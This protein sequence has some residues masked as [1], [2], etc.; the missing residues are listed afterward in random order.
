M[1]LP[2]NINN[3]F[4]NS[5]DQKNL[6]THPVILV[7]NNESKIFPSKNLKGKICLS[8]FVSISISIHGDITLCGC[9]DWMPTTVGNIYNAPLSELL[10]S[11]LAQRI[12]KSIVDGTYIFCNEKTC[13]IIRNNLLNDTHTVPDNVV[14]Q[15]QDSNRYRMPKEIFIAGDLTCNLSC[16]S[17]RTKII[18]LTEQQKQQQQKLVDTFRNN[19]FSEPSDQEIVLTVS[20]SGE[21]FA[22]S[23]LLSFISGISLTNYPNLGLNIQTNGL[24]CEKNWSRL[25]PLQQSVKKI[26]VTIDAAKSDTYEKLRRGGTWDQIMSSMA[27]LQAKKKQNSMALHTR[28]VIQ[29]DNFDQMED[30]Y[31]MSKNFDADVV[32]YARISDWKTMPT[33]KFA[34]IDVLNPGHPLY[35]EANRHWHLV[36]DR[37]DVLS[38][39]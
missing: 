28:L 6:A 32:E 30:F 1:Q 15:I 8:P 17:C 22:S 31:I 4:M 23:F 33:E 35:Q 20:T 9:Q 2:K 18:K 10:S 37:S 11:D 16:P 39:G 14:W 26:T 5:R 3:C 25:G 13:G 19:I 27:W 34:D 24:L 36:K 12:R 21:L 29:K 7:K 38:W